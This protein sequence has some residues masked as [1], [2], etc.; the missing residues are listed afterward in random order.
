MANYKLVCVVFLI[1]SLSSVLEIASDQ[2][3]FEV[4]AETLC[5]SDPSA[6]NNSVC[7]DCCN[8]IFGVDVG[9]QCSEVAGRDGACVCNKCQDPN[10]THK[11]CS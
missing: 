2:C 3:T 10:F 9:V 8:S 11:T 6:T 7:T 4:H 5:N 1:A